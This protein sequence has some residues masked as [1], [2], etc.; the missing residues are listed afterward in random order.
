[1]TFEESIETTK[2]HSIAGT[3]DKSDPFVRVRPFRSP[4]HTVSVAGITGGGTIPHPGEISL[5][6]NGVLFLDELP[7]FRRDVMEAL[8]QP[9]ED[10]KV[11]ISRVAGTLTYPSSVMLVAAMNPCPCGFFGH[12]SREC[13]CTN[14]A[15]RKYLNRISGP[16]LDRIDL[17]VEVPP[18]NYSE[19]SAVSDGE[20]SAKIKERVNRA[21]RLQTERYKGTGVTCN[22]RLTSSMLKKY[23]VMDENAQRYLRISFD[24]LGMS[25]R[26]YDRLLKVA[27]TVADLEGS[28]II[29]KEHIFAA[30]SFRTLDKKYWNE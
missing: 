9:L 10:G 12:P 15:V 4:H 7:E 16:M 28:E 24:R 11:T 22:A 20:S 17:H 27:R 19:L 23:C 13:I 26:T 6:H 14:N 29:K 18:V 21:R 25:A 8:R 2:I 5:A 3:L 1:M 30:I